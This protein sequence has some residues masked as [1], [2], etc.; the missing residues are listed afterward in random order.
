MLT[1]AEEMG[2]SGMNLAGRVRRAFHTL[3][4]QKLLDLFARIRQSCSERH[5]VYMRDGQVEPI[6]LLPC[7]VTLLP[8]QVGYLHFVSQTIH[9]ALSRLPDL[10]FK[11]DAVRKTLQLSDGEEEW[12]RNCWG[13]G[14]Q[15]S[16]PIFGRLDAVADFSS[17]MWKDSLRFVEPNMSGIG[18]LHL[19]PMCEE[20]LS[21]CVLPILHEFDHGLHLETGH[22][23]RELL[24]QEMLDHLETIGRPGRTICFIEPRFATSGIDEQEDVARFYHERYGLKV[25]HADPTELTIAAGEVC[26]AGNVIDLA[27]RDYSVLDL[28]TLQQKGHDVEPMRTLFREN[29]IISSIAAE[30]DQ[31]SCWEIFTDPQYAHY[32]DAS[33]RQVFR[34]HILWTR[35]LAQRTTE[36]PD[37][38]QGDLLEYVRRERETLVL[39]PNRSYGGEGV[40]IG[41]ATAQSDW[42]SA[43]EQSLS[44]QANWVV[45]QLASIP[46]YEFPVVDEFDSIHMEPFYLVMGFAPSKY[47][48]AILARASQKQVVNIAQRGGIC[49]IAIGHPPGPLIGPE[50]LG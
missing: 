24:M 38:R 23:S 2:L 47:G 21:E 48:V 30:L 31:K 6:R 19:V 13:A 34:R 45:Q 27:Y 4:Q 9:N 41:L 43:I 28:L 44:D 14:H 11:D 10:Y 20:I 36:L 39:K 8:D 15:E 37:S 22:D 35:T 46:V 3:D 33:E 32:F 29:R 17:P 40:L 18:G 49:A 5:V 50:R 26:F 25:L 12:L 16:N 42:E 1:P 7:P